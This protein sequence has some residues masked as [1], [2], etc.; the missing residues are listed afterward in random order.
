MCQPWLKLWTWLPGRLV[1]ER[2]TEPRCLGEA[3]WESTEFD[4]SRF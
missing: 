2:P 3:P 4:K 1:F